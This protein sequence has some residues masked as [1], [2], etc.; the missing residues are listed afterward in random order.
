[1]FSAVVGCNKRIIVTD[2][3]CPVSQCV[4]HAGALCKN[5]WTNRGPVP[6]DERHTVLEG[7]PNSPMAKEILCTVH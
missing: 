5:S 3:P 1:M 2:N 4:S 6:A 7:D